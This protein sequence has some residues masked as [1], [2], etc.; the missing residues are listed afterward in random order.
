MF[1]S[2]CGSLQESLIFPWMLDNMELVH[3]RD[4]NNA[5]GPILENCVRI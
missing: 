4:G 3:H 2:W 1:D 5:W